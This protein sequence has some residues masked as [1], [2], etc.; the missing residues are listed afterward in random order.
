V[1]NNE[2]K[3]VDFFISEL[4]NTMRNDSILIRPSQSFGVLKLLKEKVP[5]IKHRVRIDY[6][7]DCDELF[8][9]SQLWL[10]LSWDCEFPN[11][12]PIAQCFM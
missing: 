7:S 1:D 2:R 12:G 11:T 6:I 10:D 4:T 5:S 3:I 8:D 9:E